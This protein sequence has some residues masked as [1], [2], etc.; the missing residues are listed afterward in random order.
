MSQWCML[1]VGSAKIDKKR[2]NRNIFFVWTTI[3]AYNS[4]TSSFKGTLTHD[5][6]W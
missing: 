4:F 5:V 3:V 2:S 6:V 1:W